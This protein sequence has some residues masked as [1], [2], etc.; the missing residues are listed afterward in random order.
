MAYGAAVQWRV[1]WCGLGSSLL[2]TLNRH[3]PK[4]PRFALLAKGDN[5]YDSSKDPRAI[6]RDLRLRFRKAMPKKGGSENHH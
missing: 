1:S 3:F 4:A 2:M 5:I 6:L